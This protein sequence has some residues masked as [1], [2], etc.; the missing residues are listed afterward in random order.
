[1]TIEVLSQHFNELLKILEEK[2]SRGGF[3]LTEAGFMFTQLAPMKVN[4]EELIKN[5][6]ASTNTA[7]REQ[8]DKLTLELM[9]RGIQHSN[10]QR[11]YNVLVERIQELETT[12]EDSKPKKATQQ[13]ISSK[14]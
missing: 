3:T 6:G 10:L 11:E 1:M 9:E 5:K 7:S 2:T 12:I 4:I 14:N 8:V 13:G